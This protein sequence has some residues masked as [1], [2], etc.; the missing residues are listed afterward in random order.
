M[1]TSWI[2]AVSAKRVATIN[3]RPSSEIASTDADRVS[4]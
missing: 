4:R 3:V 2:W 1:R